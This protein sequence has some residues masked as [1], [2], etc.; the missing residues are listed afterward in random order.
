MG[1][2]ASGVIRFL[3]DL[4]DFLRFVG[5]E[6]IR[7]GDRSS[8]RYSRLVSDPPVV[9]DPSV[10]SH[11]G[12]NVIAIRRVAKDQKE[13]GFGVWRSHQQRSLVRHTLANNRNG[14]RDFDWRDFWR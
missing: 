1:S 5:G 13:G 6:L 4:V 3:M 14:R 7:S 9:S 12:V 2:G 11:R 8:R 10:V